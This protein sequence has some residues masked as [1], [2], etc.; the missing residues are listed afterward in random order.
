MTTMMMSARGK[1]GGRAKKHMKG[2]ERT[3]AFCTDGLKQRVKQKKVR[4][5]KKV[6]TV[7]SKSWLKMK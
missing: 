3:C 1:G 2:S 7:E 4:E 5:T 6:R